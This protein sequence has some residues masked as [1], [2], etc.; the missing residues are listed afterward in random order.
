MKRYL[1]VFTLLL[2]SLGSLMAQD[3]KFVLRA[4]NSTVEGAQIQIQ[5]ILSANGSSIENPKS[6][7]VT[8]NMPGFDV[9]YGPGVSRAQS[10]S[11][12]NGK[13]SSESSWTYTY[14]LMAKTKGKYTIPAASIQV[15]SKTYKSNTVDIEILTPDKDAQQKQQQRPGQSIPETTSSSTA[16]HIDPKDA[17]IR[18][19]FSK[20]KVKEQEALVVTFRLYSV[21]DIVG[22]NNI[23]FPDFEGFVKEEFNMSQNAQFRLEKYNGK[24]Y[25][26]ADIQKYL[27]FPQR[28]GKLTIPSGKVELFFRLPVGQSR[29]FMGLPVTVYDEVLHTMKTTPVTIDISSLPSDNKPYDFSGAVG[30]DFGFFSSISKNHVKANEAITLKYIINGTGNIKLIKDPQVEFPKDFEVYDP[31]TTNDVRTTE[32]GLSGSRTIEYMFIPRYAGEYTIPAVN[33]S[34][35]DTK[36]N[37]Y[38]TIKSEE[39]KITVDKDPNASANTSATSYAS[40]REVEVEQ[41]IRYLKTGTLNFRQT[42]DFFIGSTGYVLAYIIPLLLLIGLSVYYRN[43]IKANADVARMRTKKANKVATK[44]LKLAKRYLAEQKNDSFYEEVLRAVW[45]YLSDKLTI[46]V[47]DLN[48]ENIENELGKYGVDEALIRDYIGILDTCEFA[49][50]APSESNDAM[51]KVYDQTVDAIGKMENVIK[52]S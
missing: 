7:D 22:V 25:S 47:A 20:T 46:P 40:Q 8:E 4:P 41:D 6:P 21:L 1:I 35:F 37:K 15:G 29:G 31:K 51:D 3:V 36:D 12:I 48:R 44:R 45:G 18:A 17:F 2:I 28:S 34:Y 13:V 14:T 32:N 19:I 50:Y 24:N 26:A 38:H 9:I 42:D 11:I 43:Q 23:V 27:L 10:T 16:K 33:F 49:R 5:Y 52:K 30:R 39:Y